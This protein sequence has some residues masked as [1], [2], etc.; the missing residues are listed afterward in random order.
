MLR[1]AVSVKEVQLRRVEK[2]PAQQGC[3][4]PPAE[5]FA[6]AG[7]VCRRRAGAQVIFDLPEFRLQIDAETELLRDLPEPRSDRCKGSLGV[8]ACFYSGMA[9]IQQIRYLFVLRRAL[10]RGGDHDKAQLRVCKYDA[11]YLPEA[12]CVCQRRAAEFCCFHR[13]SPFKRSSIS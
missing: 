12:G 4:H 7:T 3:Q 8:C 1:D 2:R 13:A 6:A 5:I 11:L 9:V 10:S